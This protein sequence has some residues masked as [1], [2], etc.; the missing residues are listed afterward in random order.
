MQNDFHNAMYTLNSITTYA[1]AMCTLTACETMHNMQYA[2]LLRY[3]LYHITT[4]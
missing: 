2:V 3:A 4:M 1:H